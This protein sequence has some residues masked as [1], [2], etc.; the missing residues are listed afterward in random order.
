M[1]IESECFVGRLLQFTIDML[2]VD[3]ESEGSVKHSVKYEIMFE[4]FATHSPDGPTHVRASG[5]CLVRCFRQ[6]ALHS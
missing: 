2:E 5:G 3:I 6:S 1:E 4:N